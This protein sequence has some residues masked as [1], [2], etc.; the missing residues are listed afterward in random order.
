MGSL[1]WFVFLLCASLGAA[2][3]V[4]GRVGAAAALEESRRLQLHTDGDGSSGAVHAWPGYLYTRAVG[5]C[6]PQFWSS[7]AEPWPNIVPQEAAVAK[8]FGSRSMD[9]YGPR[10]TLLEATMRTDD[11]GGAPFVKLVKEGSAALLNAY[12]RRG[13]PLDS[14]EVK[15]LLLEALVSEEAAAVQAERFEQANESCS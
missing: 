10:L 4:Y 2:N 7:G 15:A 3:G 11:V 6:T 1:A 8:V 12:T 14:W 9:R 13:F 5:R